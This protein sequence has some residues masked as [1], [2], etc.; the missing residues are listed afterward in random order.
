MKYNPDELNELPLS[1]YEKG[2]LT[3]FYEGNLEMQEYK[4]PNGTW[5][6]HLLDGENEWVGA[7]VGDRHF[8][9]CMYFDLKPDPNYPDEL[10][11]NEEYIKDLIVLAYECHPDI[12]GMGNVTGT[13][14]TDTSL[15]Y[16]LKEVNNA[17]V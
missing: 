16:Y 13:Y 10:Y 8:D 3:A 6:E 4:C 11:I 5:Y 1:D 17:K 2:Y 7:I 14:S 15:E 9:L 12:D